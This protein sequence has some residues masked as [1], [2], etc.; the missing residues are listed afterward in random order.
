MIN[1]GH[2]SV[3][4]HTHPVAGLGWERRIGEGWLRE[5]TR[6]S[7]GTRNFA[8]ELKL[9][10]ASLD[11]CGY[12]HVLHQLQGV[13]TLLLMRGPVYLTFARIRYARRVMGLRRSVR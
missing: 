11:H 2:I 1:Q 5:R 12:T 8:A 9:I 10:G 6:P 13:K 3:S 7:Q 4:P